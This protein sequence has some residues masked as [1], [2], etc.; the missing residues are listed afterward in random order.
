MSPLE[1]PHV[2]EP[3]QLL[4]Q[5]LSHTVGGRLF[6]SQLSDMAVGGANAALGSG[7]VR[8][9]SSASASIGPQRPPTA[10]AGGGSSLAGVFGD[11]TALQ[12]GGGTSTTFSADYE[13][14]EDVI[15][16]VGRT[17]VRLLQVIPK[18]V[19]VFFPSYRWIEK[20]L[21]VWERAPYISPEE[22]RTT[23]NSAAPGGGPRAALTTASARAPSSSG[24]RGAGSDHDRLNA[25]SALSIYDA[26][27]QLARKTVLRERKD[28][29]IDDLKEEYERNVRNPR[30]GGCVL[31]AAHRAKC[32]EGISFTNDLCRGVI[33]VGI[34]L[35]SIGEP[36]IVHKRA[37]ND[38]WVRKVNENCS[39]RGQGGSGSSAGAAPSSGSGGRWRPAAPSS[40]LRPSA[41]EQQQ[42][43]TPPVHGRVLGAGLS[44]GIPPRARAMGGALGSAGE[45]VPSGGSTL[46]A[47]VNSGGFG[48]GST[49]GGMRISS[50]D[51]AA[52]HTGAGRSG[53]APK[54]RAPAFLDDGRRG[55]ETSGVEGVLPVA[56]RRPGER[57]SSTVRRPLPGGEW[58]AQQAHR[59]INQALGRCIRHAGDYGVVFLLDARWTDDPRCEGR[60]P[61][62][63]REGCGVV[64]FDDF[65]TVERRCRAHFQQ[66][67]GAGA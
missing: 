39:G 7:G 53:A 16:D 27:E 10:L 29:P 55:F 4:V 20:S 6:R 35:P 9:A 37:Y 66:F 67:A 31:L 1:A 21:D 41:A 65:A 5:K 25:Q 62:W 33:A 46:V 56:Q 49:G 11:L 48:A 45:V 60:L 64:E 59:Q 58:Y 54:R 32:G 26:I 63:I 52:Q 8:G 22:G 12:A 47:A 23:S 42:C 36:S 17:I 30:F 51:P 24:P 40:A 2:I 13:Y 44:A 15:A 57:R 14:R 50:S 19:L 18:G 28:T 3:H 43:R 38:G 34:P 61:K